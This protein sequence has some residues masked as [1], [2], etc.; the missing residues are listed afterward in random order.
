M[1][2]LKTI[3]WVLLTGGIKSKL[4]RLPEHRP[5]RVVRAGGRLLVEPIPT[6]MDPDNPVKY[7]RG[8]RVVVQPHAGFHR[9]ARGEVQYHAPDGRVWI[10]RDG[11]SFDV[12]YM[13]HE[14]AAEELR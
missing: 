13:P 3:L 9:G 14:L 7:E 4:L 1:S 12:W 11:A 8:Q 10:R 6:Q 5:F 2:W